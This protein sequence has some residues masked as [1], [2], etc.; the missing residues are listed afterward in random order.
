MASFL[1]YGRQTIEED[2]IAAVAECLRGDYLTTGPMV[3]TFEAS[4]RDATGAKFAIACSNGTAALHLAALAA[5]LGPGDQVIVPSLTF[6][7]TANAPH[8]AGADV[9]FADV[10]ASTGLLTAET[11]LEALRRAPQAKAVFPVHLNGACVEMA[12]IR[13]VASLNKLSLIED[14]CHAL[15]T[16]YHEGGQEGL[17]GD[18]FYSDMCAFS[19]HPVKA[20]AMGEGGAVTTN[21][22]ALADALRLL[23][24]HG[25]TRDGVSFTQSE[26][27]RDRNGRI[28]PWYYEMA[29]P[30]FNY[31][32][33]DIL[34]ALGVS[35]LRKLERFISR[36]RQLA[37]QYDAAFA[38]LSPILTPVIGP[39]QHGS[40]YHLY[41]VSISFDAL[42]ITRAQLMDELRAAGIGTQV[43]YF[44]VHRQPY[45]R[46]KI[47]NLHLP[48]ADSYYAGALSLPLFPAMQDEDVERVA[49]TLRKLLVSSAGRVPT[50]AQAN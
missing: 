50:M 36:R 44:P 4:L 16:I 20:I 17:I 13:Q 15:G 11:L 5:G 25:M 49:S 35:Q 29:Q 33:P 23:R 1:P 45:Y 10:D 9:V 42:R 24:N 3:E 2:D 7:A 38:D 28:N 46:A 37:A 27:A 41:A 43:H 18:S 19:F 14:A 21:T 40:A 30:G 34:C 32:V 22:P 48:G 39:G 47:G 12:K 31:R 26:E 6:L 8:L